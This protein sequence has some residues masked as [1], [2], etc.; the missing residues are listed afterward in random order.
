MHNLIKELKISMA[1]LRQSKP[2]VL[3]LTNFVTMDLMANSLLALGAAPLMTQSLEEVE[4]LVNISQAVYINIGTLDERFCER[5]QRAATVARFQ[6]KTVILDPVGA[7]ASQ[8][9]TEAAK[10]F[11]A[12]ADIIRGNASEIL[13]LVDEAGETKGV[14][15]SRSVNQAA[16]AAKTLASSLHKVIVVSGP[17]DLV[18]NSS[19]EMNL[20]F[21]SPLMPLVTGMGCT[22]TAVIAAFA[23]TCESKYNASLLATAY[24]GLCGQTAYQQTQEPGSFRQVFV[25]RLFKPDWDLFNQFVLPVE[26]M[27]EYA[28]D[29]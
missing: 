1:N 25:D 12:Y 19:E 11:L 16:A 27:G 17:I 9:R 4:E 8:L 29:A 14:E 5:A 15:A 24:F 21:G 23:A 20:P 2:L 10:S 3:C 7:G 13:A 6:K 28:C 22:L 18:T 26:K